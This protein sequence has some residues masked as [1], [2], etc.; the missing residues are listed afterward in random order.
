MNPEQALQIL[1]NVSNL[2]ISKGGIFTTVEEAASV[3][4]AL[5]ILGVE[6]Q[7]KKP[8]KSDTK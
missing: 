3:N 7:P 6:I 8:Q 5:H 1:R 2:C 4:M